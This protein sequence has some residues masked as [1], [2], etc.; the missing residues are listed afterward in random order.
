MSFDDESPIEQKLLGL[1]PIARVRLQLSKRTNLD[2]LGSP[3]TTSTIVIS[4]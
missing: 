1:E 2:P 4:A 3:T